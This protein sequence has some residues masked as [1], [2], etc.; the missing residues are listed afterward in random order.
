LH[1]HFLYCCERLGVPGAKDALDKMLTLDYIISNEDRHF[2]NFGLLRN[3]ET[4][5]WLGLA[6]IFDSG[7]S[8]WH[9]T[10]AIGS[11]VEC[12]PFTKNHASQIKLVEDLSWF[13]SR[14]L[15]GLD[16]EI[17]EIFSQAEYTRI[18]EN[19]RNRIAA[20]VMERCGQIERMAN[21]KS[22]S[23]CGRYFIP[24]APS[25]GTKEL[26][27]LGCEHDPETDQWSHTDPDKAREAEKSLQERERQR[28]ASE[29]MTKR[30]DFGI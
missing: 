20:A 3:A 13:D 7:T 27:A 24:N 5:E 29:D 6:P 15:D 23:V 10:P 19:R 11:F 18:D 12:K 17:I 30:N 2:N 9:D 25:F 4:L 8:L 28:A 16:G 21:E 22:L 14:S 26:K 1:G